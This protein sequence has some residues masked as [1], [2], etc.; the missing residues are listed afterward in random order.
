MLDAVTILSGTGVLI[1]G[2]VVGILGGKKL[3]IWKN[4]NGKFATVEKSVK[5]GGALRISEEGLN[6]INDIHSI[7]KSEYLTDKEH[8]LKCGKKQSDMMLYVAEKLDTHTKTIIAEIK[9]LREEKSNR[10]LRDK[11]Y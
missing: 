4:G 7:I 5:T 1:G 10:M 9:E 8:E 3:P 2:V 11:G 6:K